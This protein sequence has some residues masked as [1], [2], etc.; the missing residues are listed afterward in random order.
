MTSIGRG[1][2]TLV[3]LIIVVVIAFGAAGIATGLNHPP[4][5]TLARDQTTAG[6]AEVTLILD[7]A[8][9]RLADLA[10]DV[11]SLGGEARTALAA[12]NGT[13]TATAEAAIA[14]GDE[15]IAG[16]LAKASDIRHGLASAPYVG[17]PTVGIHLSDR[18]I[19][20]HAAFVDALDATDGLDAAWLRLSVGSVAAAKMSTLLAE[21]DRLV[22]QAVDRGRAARYD[23]A[24][25]KIAEAA[26]QLDV[27]KVER[28]QLANTVDVSTLD[29][30]IGRNA[31]YDDALRDL[32]R[33]IPKVGKKV[34][35]KIRAAVKAEEDA[36]AR[37]PPDTRGL[38]LIMADIGRGGMNG[39]VI[40][41]EQARAEID[42]ALTN[43][44]GS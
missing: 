21:H 27:A 39:A 30:W 24:I 35:P 43:G 23:D 4:S 2:A 37:L 42:D 7:G 16:I 8:E 5:G 12:L 14:A 19:A 41:I 1:L 11:A 6:D 25:K 3:W 22:T 34:T 18:V 15:L 36:R 26:A 13:D 31:A 38:V 33:V 40:A 29:E 28:D 44:G 10:A 20:R 32:Y 9:A 17:T